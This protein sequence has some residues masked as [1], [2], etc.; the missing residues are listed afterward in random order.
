MQVTCDWTM[1]G[2]GLGGNYHCSF[3]HFFL[4]FCVEN[5]IVCGEERTGHAGVLIE[6]AQR[7]LGM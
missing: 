2:T 7:Q 5:G 4:L 6:V 1:L 3:F